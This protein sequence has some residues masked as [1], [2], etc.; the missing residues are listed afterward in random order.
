MI[1][2][3]NNNGAVDFERVRAG[4]TRRVYLK[5]SEGADFAD[6]D[7]ASFRGRAIAA[8]LL[9]GEYH[10]ARPSRSSAA[11]E[12]LHFLRLLP[13]LRPGSSL[14]P[15][16]DLEDPNATPSPKI[17][18]WASE[19]LSIVREKSGHLPIIY[20]SPYYLRACGFSKPL[21]PL[22]LASYGRNDGKEYPY[23]V[24]VPWKHAAAHQYASGARV[25]GVAGKVDVS[26]VFVPRELDIRRRSILRRR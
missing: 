11:S 22:W 9:V 13:D 26:H 18:A 21:A 2:L 23:T 17:A 3:S 7:H 14:R 16:L 25:A 19:W 10:F 12:A 8:G 24:P 15:C 4:G 5:L 20:G 1:D 6:P